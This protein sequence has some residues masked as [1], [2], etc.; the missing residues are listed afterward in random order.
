MTEERDGKVIKYYL[1]PTISIQ[2]MFTLDGEYQIFTVSLEF[3]NF[4]LSYKH[5]IKL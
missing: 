4:T 1:I 2:D 3:L 5:Q